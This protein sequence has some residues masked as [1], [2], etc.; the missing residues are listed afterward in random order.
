MA[1]FKEALQGLAN[2]TADLSS[3]AA[4]ARVDADR[5]ALTEAGTEIRNLHAEGRGEGREVHISALSG[6]LPEGRTFAASGRVVTDLSEA[7]LFLNLVRPVDAVNAADLTVRLR[8]GVVDVDAPRL[9]TASGPVTLRASIPL[10][11]LA[12]I[13][14]LAEAMNVRGVTMTSSPGPIPAALSAKSS[15]SVPLA[16]AMPCGAPQYSANSASNARTSVPVQ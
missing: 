9:E 10:G 6:E 12:Q 2:A 8:S 15:A 4:T 13:P 3:L 5:V 7:D 14:Q 11:S 1:T 16:S